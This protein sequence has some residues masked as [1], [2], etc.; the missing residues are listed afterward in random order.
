M[1]SSSFFEESFGNTSLSKIKSSH[2]FFK[3]STKRKLIGNSFRV[4]LE[5]SIKIKHLDLLTAE[6]EIS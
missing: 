1:G 5:A 4:P 6:S 2:S 3:F